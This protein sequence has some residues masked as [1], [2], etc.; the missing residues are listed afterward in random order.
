MYSAGVIY[1][2]ASL[3]AELGNC[4]VRVLRI[5]EIGVSSVDEMLMWDSSFCIDGAGESSAEGWDGS[6]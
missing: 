3:N 2:P 6:E 4:G 5:E 1:I